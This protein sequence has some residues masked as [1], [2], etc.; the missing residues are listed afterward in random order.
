MAIDF[1]EFGFRRKGHDWKLERKKK[2]E[3]TDALYIAT[4]TGIVINRVHNFSIFF[5]KNSSN[6]L[7]LFFFLFRSV[8]HVRMSFF[9]LSVSLWFT[10]NLMLKI[11]SFSRTKNC[12]C[13][14]E[15]QLHAHECYSVNHCAT[16]YNAM[17]RPTCPHTIRANQF[18]FLRSKQ[19][20]CIRRVNEK[21]HR[22]L[23]YS[24]SRKTTQNWKKKQ[25][26]NS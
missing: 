2:T 14:L 4:I 9:Y 21:C 11:F 24:C 19:S 3:L 20:S 22:T 15:K 12:R 18:S 8:Q 5:Q 1:C 10:K 7:F 25:I 6:I 17:S 16:L 13:L 26:N 23:M